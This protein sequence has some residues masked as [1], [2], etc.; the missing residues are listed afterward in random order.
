MIIDE[1]NL[2]GLFGNK[3]DDIGYAFKLAVRLLP[4]SSNTLA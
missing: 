1:K 3:Q 4:L 2:L